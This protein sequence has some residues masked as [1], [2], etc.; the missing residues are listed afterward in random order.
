MIYDKNG[1]ALS[2]V[3]DISGNTIN[4]AYDVNANLLIDYEQY[5]LTQLYESQISTG[6][7]PQGM[8]AYGDYIF[9][10]FSTSNKMKVLNKSNYSLVN[11]MS[12][13]VIGHGNNLQF[14]D[15]VQSNGFPYLYASDSDSADARYIYVLSVSTSQLSLVDTI[16]LPNAVGN[17]PNAVID[18]TNNKIYT[19]GYTASSVYTTSGKNVFCILDLSNPSTVID[20]WQYDY[21]GV[22]NGLVWDGTHV[23][24]NGNTWDGTDVKF[25]FLNPST[26]ANDMT[27]TFEKEYDSEFQGMSNENGWLL[28]SKWLYKTVS[29]SRKLF[30]AF[31]RLQL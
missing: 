23:I 29:G 24:Y 9:Q 1:N 30:Y 7:S 2:S 27:L 31:Y 10:F 16:T 4:Q 12:C 11:E 28:V 20:T 19:V 26:E 21:L 13:T 6:Q 5:S 14:G 17:F 8:A 3:Y 18:F 22:M 25:H 15:T